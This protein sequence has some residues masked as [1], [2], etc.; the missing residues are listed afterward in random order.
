MIAEADNGALVILSGGLDSTVCMQIAW[1]HITGKGANQEA[2]LEN[3][4]ASTTSLPSHIDRL[5][6]VSFDYGQRASNEL[7]CAKRVTQY[8]RCEHL[9]VE[10][11]ASKWGG[12]SL[13]DTSIDV[14]MEG[15]RGAGN[16]MEG[17]PVTRLYTGSDP[18]DFTTIPNTY[19]PARNIIFLSI[20]LGIAEAKNLNNIYIG[21]NALDYSGYPDCR[22]EFIQAFQKVANIGLKRCIEGNPITIQTPLISLTKAEIIRLGSQIGAPL[23]LSWSCYLNGSE[24]CLKCESCT[25]RMRGF[26]EAGLIDPALT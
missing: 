2:N 4:Q 19:V 8:Y 7:D 13:T 3:N 14:P 12:S 24:P 20:A 9:I 26:S 1:Q 18:S 15:D 5:L 10:L 16:N 11:D 25:I 23:D 6:A 17:D 22:P 21:V